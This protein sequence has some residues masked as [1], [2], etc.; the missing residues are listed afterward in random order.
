PLDDA[1]P[2]RSVSLFNPT[3]QLLIVIDW[4][5]LRAVLSQLVVQAS[6]LVVRRALAIAF[7]LVF[8]EILL[9]TVGLSAS[10]IRLPF[11]QPLLLFDPCNQ[12]L[13]FVAR[14]PLIFVVPEVGIEFSEFGK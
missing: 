9:F 12:F 4:K 1:G 2:A 14:E 13:I 11:A 7:A 6:Q 3:S 5:L 10:L 8:E